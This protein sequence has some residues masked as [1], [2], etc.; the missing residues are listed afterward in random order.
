MAQGNLNPFGGADFW[1]ENLS[2]KEFAEFGE[3][4][5]FEHNTPRVGFRKTFDSRKSMYGEGLDS[6][7]L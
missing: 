7:S 3:F 4:V 2:R 1:G 6:G 5:R